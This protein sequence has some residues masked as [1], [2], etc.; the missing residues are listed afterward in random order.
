MLAAL[1]VAAGPAG[2]VTVQQC[3]QAGSMVIRCA[4]QPVTN[5]DKVVSPAPGKTIRLWCVG[6]TFYTM[7]DG[8][9]MEV[10]DTGCNSKYGR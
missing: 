1:V 10:F 6:T 7:P 3:E 8:T 4:E 5:K 2:A 9:P